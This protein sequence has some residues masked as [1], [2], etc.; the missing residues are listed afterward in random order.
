MNRFI[1]E[2]KAIIIKRKCNQL[3]ENNIDNEVRPLINRK[4]LKNAEHTANATTYKQL[5]TNILSHGVAFLLNFS[6]DAWIRL[7][8]CRCLIRPP[9]H[10]SQPR[11]INRK[12]M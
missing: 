2:L 12:T 10:Q 7:H 4:L 8:K 11:E 1:N 5:P 3:G 9:I 6:T